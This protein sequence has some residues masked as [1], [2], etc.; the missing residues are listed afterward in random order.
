MKN[1]AKKNFKSFWAV[2]FEVSENILSKKFFEKKLCQNNF[3]FMSGPK[4][5]IYYKDFS[6]LKKSL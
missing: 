4:S 2:I 3:F 6:F 1:F 5:E